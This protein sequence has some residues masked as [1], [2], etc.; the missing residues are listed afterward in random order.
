MTEEATTERLYTKRE[1]A[2]VLRCSEIT[3]HRLIRLKRLGHFRV[4][5]RVFVG[6]SHIQAYL[7]NSERKSEQSHDEGSAQR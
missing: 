4:A 5:S 1:A 2:G 7:T 3:V 6:E